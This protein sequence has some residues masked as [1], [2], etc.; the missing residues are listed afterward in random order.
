[1]R[2]ANKHA[3]HTGGS[4]GIGQEI[5]K[6]LVKDGAKVKIQAVVAPHDGG[7]GRVA[8]DRRLGALHLGEDHA[9]RRGIE[10]PEELDQVEARTLARGPGGPVRMQ[11]DD[12]LGA[13][14]RQWH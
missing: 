7:G 11:D 1:M 6:G 2:L 14:P 10:A 9:L 8:A 13:R 4:G 12:V 3:I 5:A